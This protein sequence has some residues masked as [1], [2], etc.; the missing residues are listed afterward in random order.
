MKHW[1]ELL[2]ETRVDLNEY[3]EE[4]LNDIE[5]MK[6]KQGIKQRMGKKKSNQGKKI[7][8]ASSIL[9]LSMAIINSEVI[10]DQIE[11]LISK[12]PIDNFENYKGANANGYTNIIDQTVTNN[13]LAITINEVIF[14]YDE[15]IIMYTMS[16]ENI[17]TQ[18]LHITPKIYIDGKKVEIDG[19]SGTYSDKDAN[20]KQVT[21]KPRVPISKVGKF[22]MRVVIGGKE[23]FPQDALIKNG[24]WKY[25]F[26]VSNEAMKN[27]TKEFDI[28]NKITLQDGIN[29]TIEKVVTTPISTTVEIK[30]DNIPQE[31]VEN[32]MIECKVE[33]SE[34]KTLESISSNH[35]YD[36]I[37][38]L[39][40]ARL[41]FR[42]IKQDSKSIK[43][44]PMMLSYRDDDKDNKY[45]E[46]LEKHSFEVNL[47]IK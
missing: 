43:I 24:K 41:K 42:N 39:Y 20:L 37:N 23:D 31:V 28:H 45:N 7:A 22:D 16:G 3:S 1:L 14:D 47:N 10:A 19:V 18:S 29:V 44:T 34:S 26:E 9:V 8:I 2:N 46:E 30:S 27:A 4:E 5:K 13:G 40:I 33:D 12:N 11:R 25:N 17:D 15:I 21:L 6:L 36:G 35:S 38:K 32:L